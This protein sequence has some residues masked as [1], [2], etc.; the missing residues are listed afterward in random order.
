MEI[1]KTWTVTLCE[2][3]ENHVGMQKIGNEIEHGFDIND[4][5]EYQS[6]FKSHSYET[7]LHA[8]HQNDGQP[9]A[10]LLII[11]NGISLFDE[12]HQLLDELKSLKYDTLVFMR[13]EVKNKKARYNLCFGYTSQVA[14]FEEGKGTVIS[15]EDV[16]IVNRI[17]IGIEK[18]INK[19]NPLYGE[20]NYY[21]DIKKTGIGYH[22]DSERKLVIGLRQGASMPLFFKWYQRSK[23]VG[24]TLQF[25]LHHNDIYFMSEKTVGHDWHKQ[26]I[27]TLRHATGCDRY[28]KK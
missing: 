13:G 10:Y 11:R 23:Q 9:E 24:E 28:T 3:A 25:E 6:Y 16:P 19:K 5:I 15:F 14:C 27:F 17:K 12:N 26:K 4:L 1:Q 20:V 8:L 2:V 22:G 21:Y 7:E 18:L